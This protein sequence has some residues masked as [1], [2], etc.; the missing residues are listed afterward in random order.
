MLELS[1]IALSIVMAAGMIIPFF[2]HLNRL[3]PAPRIKTKWV[4]TVLGTLGAWLA[5]LL[6][7]SSFESLCSTD[8]PPRIPLLLFV[9]FIVF[10]IR[11]YIKHKNSP[12]IQN[13]PLQYTSAMQSFRILVEIMLLYSFKENLV[14]KAAT[15]EGLNFDIL[16]GISAPFI[17]HFG[18]IRKRIPKKILVAWNI[19]GMLMVLFV[20]V[21]IA[22]AFYAPNE[23]IAVH[24]DMTT[25]FVVMP[26]LLLPAF[27][28][29]TAIFLHLVS[30]IQLR[31]FKR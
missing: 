31:G 10:M 4:Y 5:Y 27:L 19:L 29:P 14:P 23:L 9:P 12:I 3:N 8:L 22:N 11:F 2:K 17:A 18:F 6:I 26:Y 16:M 24:D 1:Y 7:L 21:I 28:A 13:I 20:G 30:L 25:D 15:F